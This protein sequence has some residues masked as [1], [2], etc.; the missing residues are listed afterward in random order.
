MLKELKT[1]LQKYFGISS[2]KPIATKKPTPAKVVRPEDKLNSLVS[3]IGRD[4]FGVH[5][6]VEWGRCPYCESITQ[7]LST[8]AGYFR[9][10]TCREMTKQYINGHI[11]YLPIDDR[12]LL[13]DDP[14]A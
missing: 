8:E 4:M 12:H 9:C 5:V 2:P 14:Q 7:M 11:A 13:G 10:S 3:E 6:K 1:L